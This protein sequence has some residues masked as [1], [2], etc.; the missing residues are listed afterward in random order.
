MDKKL[1]AISVLLGASLAGCATKDNPVNNNEITAKA[2]VSTQAI[3]TS[4]TDSKIS[5]TNEKQTCPS[6][7]GAKTI[8]ME[9][10][11]FSYLK[12]Q[13][14]IC[15]TLEVKLDDNPNW[16]TKGSG[17]FAAGFG[18]KTMKGSKMV[19]FVPKSKDTKDTQYTA[20]GNIGGGFGPSLPLYT[21]PK[22]GTV[23]ILSSS[24]GKVELAL[25]PNKVKS[26]K[27]ETHIDMIFSHSKAGLTQFVPGHIAAYDGFAMDL[28]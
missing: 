24:L 2:K 4:M 11:K 8:D 10:M 15:A 21:K 17:W 9:D 22:A 28:K 3:N 13:D 16:T 26:L 5:S 18:A 27:G 6:M 14:H 12:Y 23:E 7:D 25:Y 19:I 1:I 20:F